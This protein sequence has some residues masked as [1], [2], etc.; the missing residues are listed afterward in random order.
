MTIRGRV[1]RG[2]FSSTVPEGA[3]RG[4]TYFCRTSTPH[5]SYRVLGYIDWDKKLRYGE[6]LTFLKILSAK[7]HIYALVLKSVDDQAFARVGLLCYLG[8]W[9][10]N[11]SYDIFEDFSIE[12]LEIE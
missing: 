10:T 2:T 8:P 5:I 11:S 7:Q 6:I 1:I 4:I 3:E 12:A 9:T